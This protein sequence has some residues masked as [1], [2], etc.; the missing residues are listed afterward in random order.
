MD[1]PTLARI[2][3]GAGVLL[4]AVGILVLIAPRMPF[5][6]SFGRLPGDLVVRR[7]STTIAIPIVTSILLSVLLTVALNL[8][9]RK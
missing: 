8:F 2:L 6:G 1:G 5:V 7:G 3:I 9:L 4:F